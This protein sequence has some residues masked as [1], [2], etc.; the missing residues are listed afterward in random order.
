MASRDALRVVARADLNAGVGGFALLDQPGARSGPLVASAVALAASGAAVWI[1]TDDGLVVTCGIHQGAVP[2]GEARARVSVDDVTRVDARAPPPDGSG[3]EP[4]P[5]ERRSPDEPS[6]P[7]SSRVSALA[8]LPAAR[9]VAA[10]TESRGVTLHAHRSVVPV[11]RTRAALAVADA[12]D[13]GSAAGSGAVLL[14]ARGAKKRLELFRAVLGVRDDDRGADMLH[15]APL[16]EIGLGVAHPAR[17]VACDAGANRCV[18]AVENKGYFAVNLTSGSASE[19]Y[20]FEAE[21]KKTTSETIAAASAEHK[22]GVFRPTRGGDYD[23]M[24]EGPERNAP[25]KN[26]TLRD[27]APPPAFVLADDSRANPIHREPSSV[28]ED[29]SRMSAAVARRAFFAARANRGA[30]IGRDVS[31][32]RAEEEDEEGTQG[33]RPRARGGMLE[34][35]VLA[36]REGAGG[37]EGSEEEG[38]EEGKEEAAAL[39]SLAAAGPWIVAADAAGDAWAWDASARGERFEREVRENETGGARPL[40]GA[41]DSR[42]L[43]LRLPSQRLTP[44]PS[45][46]RPGREDLARPGGEDL[47]RTRR[48]FRPTLVAG[49][50]RGVPLASARRVTPSSRSSDGKEKSNGRGLGSMV[51]S[52]PE[53]FEAAAPTVVVVRGASV[54]VRRAIAVEA[55]LRGMLA[56]ARGSPSPVS[57]LRAAV[58]LARA[59][60]EDGVG[61]ATAES[62]EPGSVDVLAAVEAAAGHAAMRELA[63]AFAAERFAA[64]AALVDPIEVAA[65]FPTE[66]PD[67]ILGKRGAEKKTAAEGGAFRGVADADALLGETRKVHWGTHAPPEDVAKIIAETL[68]RREEAT[69]R[70]NSRRTTPAVSDPNGGGTQTESSLQKPFQSLPE[71]LLDAKRAACRYFETSLSFPLPPG[72]ARK[73]RLETLLARLRAET[74]AAGALEASLADDSAHDVDPA[75]AAY[76]CDARG[77]RLAHATITAR[78]DA[79]AALDEW[80]AIARGEAVEAPDLGPELGLGPPGAARRAATEISETSFPRGRSFETGPFREGGEAA[81]TLEGTIVT[82]GSGARALA[83]EELARESAFGRGAALAAARCAAKTLA[84]GFGAEYPTSM[85]RRRVVDGAGRFFGGDGG[86][87]GDGDGGGDGDG[88]DSRGVS[89]GVSLGTVRA[90]LDALAARHVPWILA[91][92]AGLGE[93]VLAAPRFQRATA[94]E[95]ALRLLRAGGARPRLVAAHLERRVAPGGAGRRDPRTHTELALALLEA[96]ERELLEAGESGSEGRADVAE[97]TAID[98][99]VDFAGASSSDVVASASNPSLT[100]LAHLSRLPRLYDARAV[101]DALDPRA[102]TSADAWGGLERGLARGVRVAPATLEARVTRRR[103]ELAL[104]RFRTGEHAAV[105]RLAQDL[106][107][108][109]AAR[110]AVAAAHCEAAGAAATTATLRARLRSGDVAGA[111][112]LLVEATATGEEGGAEGGGARRETL[113][114]T[115]RFAGVALDLDAAEKAA[116]AAAKARPEYSEYEAALRELRAARGDPRGEATGTRRPE[117]DERRGRR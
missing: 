44:P 105:A 98:F 40:R 82:N 97:E 100:F 32:T 70:R 7:L 3:S 58:A 35:V 67:F 17:A 94:P 41:K 14:V 83:G 5:D 117:K 61:T 37:G 9:C 75:V 106:W 51:F 66:R 15:V 92:D 2:T 18:L 116:N 63:F 110:D 84:D 107:R 43:R 62:P 95:R 28:E 21:E 91:V 89:L 101:L 55:E 87:D 113:G 68:R 42:S 29:D 64:A 8:H 99:A 90:N 54:E 88:D 10:V 108:T 78:S 16:R 104:L 4:S 57:K 48:P 79:E 80:A 13:P 69:R 26:K 34:D 38:K 6:S 23:A 114:P 74:G 96:E 25:K 85:F 45:D 19:L 52:P 49:A 73:R 86:G 39:V 27:P 30:A 50:P 81:G 72:D 46:A 102:K 65:Y 93:A 77:R 59:A 24:F 11:P 22:L 1:G 112:R 56:A 103:R 60:S 109:D 20:D 33:T 36:T 53:P 71:L 47:L 111:T 31:G 76:Y 115:R 12:T